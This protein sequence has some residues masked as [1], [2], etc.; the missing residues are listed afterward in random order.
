MGNWIS[1]MLASGMALI[2]L[3]IVYKWLLSSENQPSFNRFVI[4]GCYLL[5]SLFPFM[6]APFRLNSG[7]ADFSL[8]I[9]DISMAVI[10][11]IPAEENGYIL[12]SLII[13]L[14]LIGAAAVAGK[15]IFAIVRLRRIVSEGEV[16]KKDGYS[17]V[18]SDIP[19]ISPFSW[20]RYIVMSRGDYAN[21][22]SLIIRHELEHINRLH[23][24]DLMIARLFEIIMW[25][26]PA[27]WLMTNELRAVHEFQADRAVVSETSDPKEYQLLLIK[28]A[29]GKSF[30]ILANSLN[31][32]NLKKRITMMLK[33]Q[34][35]KSRRVRALA[36][37]PA[38]AVAMLFVNSPLVANALNYVSDASVSLFSDSKVNDFSS[39]DNVSAAVSAEKSQDTPQTIQIRKN[40]AESSSDE[41]KK[42][43]ADIKVKVIPSTTESTKD[44]NYYIDGKSA[45]KETVN[46]LNPDDVESIT[47]SKQDSR[48]EINTRSSKDEAVSSAEKMPQFPGGEIAL[49]EFMIK[50]LKYPE[51]ETTPGTYMVIVKF[52]VDKNGKVK[53]PVVIRKQSEAFNQEAIRVVSMLPDF[54]PG[55]INGKPVAVYYTL[56]INFKIKDDKPAKDVVLRSSEKMPQFPGGEKAL[57]EFVVSNI[58]YPQGATVKGKPMVVVKFVVDKT[59]KVKDPVIMRGQDE[60][61]NSEAIRVVSLLPDFEPGT[62]DGKPV[63]VAYTL[64]IIFSSK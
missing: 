46:A 33:P 49:M 53:D 14:Y 56:P 28:K 40:P 5:T 44:K 15:T 17:I 13:I 45:S 9:Q 38:V 48:I 27:A 34:S 19:R 59:G 1:Y 8:E 42:N 30:P 50:N 22:S 32:S 55:T 4:L 39:D 47:I 31:H 23:C 16:I 3:Y 26:N 57:M 54:E 37:A 6:D 60:A 58:K 63:S 20:Q 61:L 24:I 36:L 52:I 12:P 18:L 35:G 62:V 64:P 51:S 2:C 29:A 7:K 41:S 11:D 21:C 10:E 43:S 25:F